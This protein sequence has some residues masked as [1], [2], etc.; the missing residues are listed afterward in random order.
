MRINSFINHWL[1]LLCLVAVS[2][3]SSCNEGVTSQGIG[4]E[5]Q[6]LPINMD[7]TV[8]LPSGEVIVLSRNSDGEIPSEVLREFNQTN[9]HAHG[10]VGVRNELGSELNLT[11]SQEVVDYDIAEP[12]HLGLRFWSPAF[13]LSEA[14][15]PP[16]TADLAAY[17][18]PGRVFETGQG[19]GRAQLGILLPTD[20]TSFKNYRSR[21]DY[22]HNEEGSV[23]VESVAPVTIT[24]DLLPEPMTYSIITF[25]Y[26]VAVGVW[27]IP[28]VSGRRTELDTFR[29]KNIAQVE[30]TASLV[31]IIN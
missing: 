14:G 17:F 18:T 9:L 3:L 31:L 7:A 1:L 29:T 28:V 11:L 24:S 5:V 10:Y 13:S 6:A 30:G 15:A 26:E 16:T 20:D 23:T 12:F 21:T 22:A 27:N 8:Q 25:S 2:Y 4:T 19:V